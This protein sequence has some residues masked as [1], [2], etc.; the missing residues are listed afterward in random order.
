M[1]SNRANARKCYPYIN[2]NMGRSARSKHTCPQSRAH[3]RTHTR[4]PPKYI[5]IELFVSLATYSSQMRQ[6]QRQQESKTKQTNVP[7]TFNTHF[8][9]LLP[10]SCS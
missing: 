2:G 6:R 8:R 9:T 4:L 1:C 5:G 3:L 10:Y 7:Y